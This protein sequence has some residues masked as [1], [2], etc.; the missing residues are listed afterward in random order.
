MSGLLAAGGMMSRPALKAGE[1]SKTGPRIYDVV[2][3]GAKGDG[4]ALDTSAINKTIETC[5]QAGGGVVYLGPGTYLSG[6]VILKSNVTLYL[7]AGAL[8]LGSASLA[9]YAPQRGSGPDSDAN[10]RHLV[11]ARDAENIGVAGP[12]RIDGQGPKFWAPSGRAAVAPED[13]WADVAAYDWKPLPRPSP[14]LEFYNCRNLRIEE[15]RI[16][17]APGWTLRPLLCNN[18]F[19]RGISIKNPLIGP[20][21]GG[22]DL[23]CSQNVFVSDCMIDSGD[24]AICL[25]SENPYSREVAVS[26]NITVTNCVL[27]CCRN[28]FEIGAATRGGIENV[29][30]SNSV[31]FNDDV[32]PAARVLAGIALEMVDGGWLE[33]V[34]VSNIRMQRARAPIFIR[35][36]L[37]HGRPD[38]SAGT[39]RGVMIE[40][41]Q[42]TGSICASSIAGLPE[43]NVEDVRLSNI[44]IDN[45]EAGKADW[46]EA[47][48]P[49]K[50]GADP[51]ARM[52]GRL[53][54]AGLYARHVRGLRAHE[55]EF[56]FSP[57]EERPAVVLDDVRDAAIAGLRSTSIAGKQPVLKVIQSK[58]VSVRGSAAPPTTDTYLEVHGEQSEHILL[59]DNDLIYARR[60]LRQGVAVPFGAVIL[61]GN[62]HRPS[63]R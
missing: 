16:G 42:A 8:L 18:V 58:E 35:R 39:L 52:F 53:P 37:R 4:K 60:F 26:R 25:K 24:D 29:T 9:D 7:E 22:L 27:S 28:G 33:G 43:F 46:A 36:G 5:H 30:F 54:A 40:N 19:I 49:E 45:E 21:A 47:K 59:A 15:A 10:Q 55:V 17:D 41:I 51:E 6:T 63:S 50:T 3:H 14:M 57:A 1:S 32:E 62:T 13:A 20:N 61:S 12:G 31:I 38:G 34:A 48:I 56:R 23:T 2:S 11:F 44:R